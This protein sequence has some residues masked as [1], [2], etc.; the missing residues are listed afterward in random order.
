MA[1]HAGTGLLRVNKSLLLSKALLFTL[2]LPTPIKK[3]SADIYSGSYM[4][5]INSDP[6]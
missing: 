1:F 6:G 3:Q 5:H 4:E 2:L